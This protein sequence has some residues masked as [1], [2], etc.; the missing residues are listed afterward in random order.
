VQ[1]RI[2]NYKPPEELVGKIK[3]MKRKH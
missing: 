2:K 1:S 3:K